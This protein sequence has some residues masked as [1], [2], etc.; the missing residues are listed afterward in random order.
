MTLM[1]RSTA[2]GQRLRI[3]RLTE[4]G[5][6]SGRVAQQSAGSREVRN[7]RMVHLRDQ[8]ALQQEVVDLHDVCE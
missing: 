7:A 6:D 5:I 8:H 4:Q 2:T 1:R 3:T